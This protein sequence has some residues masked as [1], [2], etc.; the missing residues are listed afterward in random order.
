MKAGKHNSGQ[1]SLAGLDAW[2]CGHAVRGA[3]VFYKSGGKVKREWLSRCSEERALTKDLMAKVVSP[4]N[5]VAALRQVVSNKGS[6]GVDGMTTKE[7]Q[8]WFGS[9]YQQ[10]QHQIITGN[11]QVQ[12]V[13]EVQ[14]PKPNGGVRIL[15]I[16][17]VK[18][19]LVQQAISQVLS[20]HYDPTFSERSY[21]F[22]PDR[23]AH[24]TL[25]QA[26][27]DVSEGRGWIVD[28]D[29]EKFFDKVN[30][31]RLLWLLGT[32]V[33][34]KRLLKLIGKFLRAGLL[35]EGLV[36]QRIKGTPQG[37]PLSPLLSNIVLDELDKELEVRGHRFARYAD[38]LIVMVKSEASANR[39]LSSLTVFIEQRMLLKVNRA[40][41]KISR[42]H[43]LNF[44]GHRLLSDGRLGLSKVSENRL[45]AK[46]KQ[47]SQRNRGISLE[48]LVREL[49][50]VLRGW[51]NYF[52]KA[53]MLTKLKVLEGWLN[54]R[55][56]CFRLKQ[57]KRALSLA[58]FLHGLGVPWNRSWTTAGSSKGWYRLSITHAAHEG[59]NLKWFRS[60]GLYSL[61]E[62]YVKY[63]KKPPSTTNVRW[64][65]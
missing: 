37:S 5:L 22:R 26:T 54:R 30:H 33:G 1:M 47:L 15:G 62:N 53:Q 4:S 19:R 28:I 32:R 52:K 18:D 48:Q 23:G 43:E 29:L 20:Q 51:L 11:Y 38:D 40:K 9:H 8:E 45:K 16:P 27:Q 59:M 12:A 24:D 10:L 57:C 61:K 14:I 56:R 3:D 60:I 39:V 63:L 31:D 7:L 34:D 49:N 58:K 64:V 25:Q 35:K 6:S 2:P 13:H 46:L 17:T 41:S 42:P 55:I 65:V 21:G 36:G 44:L 50:P